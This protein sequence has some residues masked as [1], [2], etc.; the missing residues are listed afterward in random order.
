[1]N[2]PTVKWSGSLTSWAGR[3]ALKPIE[4]FGH[5]P[6][7]SSSQTP[8]WQ[9]GHTG[10]QCSPHWFFGPGWGLPTSLPRS[11]HLPSLS[12]A[13]T[14]GPT[15]VSS[16]P[17][18]PRHGCGQ[19]N[20]GDVPENRSAGLTSNRQLAFF[21]RAGRPKPATLSCFLNLKPRSSRPHFPLLTLPVHT[22]SRPIADPLT[23][24]THIQKVKVTHLLHSVSTN[25]I[26]G[27]V[28]FLNDNAE[29]A[30]RH[31]KTI[32]QSCF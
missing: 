32:S 18:A 13:S 3:S 8:L 12:S 27:H 11:T 1:M 24:H 26:Q 5:H 31:E 20:T 17:S 16:M 2:C 14:C 9:L 7:S 19:V 15:E 6:R 28:R 23:T 22:Y 10:T 29:D 25:E 4:F 21:G 30:G